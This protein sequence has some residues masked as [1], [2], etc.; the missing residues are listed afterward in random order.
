MVNEWLSDE[1]AQSYLA[2]ADRIPHR[3]EGDAVLLEVVPGSVARVLDLG[4]GDGR[5]IA[6]LKSSRPQ[7]AAVAL[8]FSPSMLLAVSERFKGDASVQIVEHN[9]E[10]PLPPLGKF[11]AIISGLAIHHCPDARKRAIY[12][13]VF[14]ILEPGGI[15]CNLDH[16]ASPTPRLHAQFRAALGR[17][18][19]PS[20][21]L[22]DLSLQLRWLEETGFK[23]V[24]CLW[25]WREL[26]LM[27]GVRL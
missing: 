25:K 17:P 12:A 11:D 2:R 24:D 4:T 13:E 23:D 1:H 27:A 5:L 16:V 15:F 9:L 3:T 10:E 21:K 19:D 6:L 26:A 18:D 20:N 14:D 22:T 8:D 7:L